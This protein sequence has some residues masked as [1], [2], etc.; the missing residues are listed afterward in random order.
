MIALDL[1]TLPA[2][3]TQIR[4]DDDE[5][6]VDGQLNGEYA[7]ILSCLSNHAVKAV[8]EKGILWLTLPKKT[9]SPRL[10]AVV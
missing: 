6:I 8:Y 4:V 10:M 5:L 2:S 7:K 3:S 9:S 1:P